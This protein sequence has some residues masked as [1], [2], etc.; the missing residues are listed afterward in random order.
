M[1]RPLKF[2]GALLLLLAMSVPIVVAAP[3]NLVG[4]AAPT[5]ALK[6]VTSGET[7]SLEALKGKI[8][9]LDFWATWCA[10][11]KEAIPHVAEIWRL[12]K[13]QNA[14]TISIDL[15][16]DE[17]AVRKFAQSNQMNW[18]VVIDRD[19][20]TAQKYDVTAIPTLFIIDQHGTVRYAHVG[21]FK[22][23]GDELRKRIGDL[24]KEKTDSITCSVSSSSITIEDSMLVSGTLTPARSTT[25]DLKLTRPD[26]SSYTISLAC[27]PDGSYSH[28]FTPDRTGKWS[29][30]AT[31]GNVASTTVS[32]EVREKAVFQNLTFIVLVATIVTMFGIAVVILVK[33]SASRP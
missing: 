21:F 5:F 23:L 18:I 12:Y 3:E 32:F 10:P 13:D 31:I 26:G 29:V 20:S 19:G 24:L 6:N 28:R 14:F 15:R 8:V 2:L 9:V 25:I 27:N 17:D 16:E 4:K 33:R 1:N 11:C 7:V 22:E 30:L